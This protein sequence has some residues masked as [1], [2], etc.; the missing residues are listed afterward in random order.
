MDTEHPELESRFEQKIK[1]LGGIIENKM[2]RLQSLSVTSRSHLAPLRAIHAEQAPDSKSTRQRSPRVTHAEQGE[3]ISRPRDS[4]RA[5]KSR[6]RRVD[7]PGAALGMT[8]QRKRKHEN[9]HEGDSAHYLYPQEQP[10]Q[11][12]NRYRDAI[13]EEGE[14]VLSQVDN[15]TQ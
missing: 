4:V 3:G 14:A 2:L 10:Q 1:E 9:V 5:T 7:A 15:N 11:G 12:Y 6:R 13:P 8:G